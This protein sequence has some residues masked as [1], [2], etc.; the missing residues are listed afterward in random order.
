MQPRHLMLATWIIVGGLAQTAVAET[1]IP[2]EFHGKWGDAN[3]LNSGDP[4]TD[5]VGRPEIEIKA[6]RLYLMDTLCKLKRATNKSSD[7][8]EGSTSRVFTGKFSC[9][10]DGEPF[11][12][13]FTF[14]LNQQ[15][16]SFSDNV[17][18]DSSNSEQEL[19][20]CR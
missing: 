15:R 4:G 8:L 17:S 11:N 14:T 10:V 2:R 13:N 6:N 12:A 9:E 5:A 18:D 3:C 19:R 20:R 7:A 16:L 1:T